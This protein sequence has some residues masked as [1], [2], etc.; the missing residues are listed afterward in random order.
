MEPVHKVLRWISTYVVYLSLFYLSDRFTS[1]YPSHVFFNNRFSCAGMSN[2]WINWIEIFTNLCRTCLNEITIDM[3]IASLQYMLHCTWFSMQPFSACMVYIYSLIFCS[4]NFLVQNFSCLY[5]SSAGS[6]EHRL[7]NRR[8]KRSLHSWYS[9][10][11][12]LSVL[13]TAGLARMQNLQ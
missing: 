1:P 3:W 2:K 6:K 5:V 13:S 7:Y 8:K 11:L 4:S 12:V 10:R 9:C